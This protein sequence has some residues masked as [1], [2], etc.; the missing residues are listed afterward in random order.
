MLIAGVLWSYAPARSFAFLNWDDQAVLLRNTSLDFPGVLRWAFTTTHMEHYQPFSW[1]AWAAIKRGFGLDPQAY[2]VANIAAHLVCVLLLWVVAQEILR[3]GWPSMTGRWRDAAS[4]AAAL[5]FGLHPLRV[6]V[7]AWISALPYAL[8]LALMLA[9]LLAHLRAA[10]PRVRRWRFAALA[11]YCGSL[12]ARPV[13][14]G[15][16]AVLVI[17]DVLLLK[18][19]ARA[20]AA[21]AT[22]FAVVAVAAA[23]GEAIARVPGLAET[24]WL[25]RAQ[26]AAIA[27]F[28]YLWHTIAPISL[29]P[30]DVLPLDPAVSPAVMIA[31]CLAL[32]A[33]IAASWVWRRRQPALSAAWFAYLA[34]LAP[35]AG[36]LPSGLQATADR[37]AYVPGV[38]IALAAALGLARWAHARPGRAR[39]VAA[40]GTLVL[41]V[42]AV[43]AR[44]AL[45]PW[46]DSV[47]LWTRV[48][49]LD[50]D[51]DVGLYNLATALAAD[52]RHADAAAR[53]RDLL[54]LHPAHPEAAANL[55]RLDAARLERE[56]ND[57]AA[58]GDLAAAAERYR[59]AVTL[60]PARTHSHAARGMALATLGRDDE[61][62]PALREAIRQGIGDAAVPNA[63]GV[64]LLQS[65]AA[66]DARATFEAA[67]VTHPGDTS[68]AHNLARLLASSPDRTGADAERALQLAGRAVQATGGRDPL[69]LETL[70]L[71]LAANDRFADARTT[72]ARAA[73]LAAA[74]GN[75]GLAEEIAAR[76]R[77]Y[78]KP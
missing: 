74:Q 46:S 56:A 35:A 47:A 51:H 13:A 54:R 14:L 29:T 72:N 52:G 36:L 15:F 76:G 11:L 9:S 70:A 2:H 38:V 50:P 68:L 34:L 7:V 41:V 66:Q 42:S 32:A 27:P 71:A 18:R 21:A 1:L 55:A 3:R 22:P 60:D 62:V 57:L 53:Y 75:T 31:A 58:A 6:E 30:L 67:L 69:A 19:S 17:V 65:G 77:A 5:L 39:V 10:P 73:A 43:A 4:A 44:Q 63:L 45:A 33:S 49:A 26:S 78:S 23:A 24:P 12:L 61:A 16:P 40:A 37:Y 8:A 64:L 20:S 48:I 25:Y 28:V 59:Q